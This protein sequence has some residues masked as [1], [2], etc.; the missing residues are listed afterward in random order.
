MATPDGTGLAHTH[1]LLLLL[2]YLAA[3]GLGHSN[4]TGVSDRID[5]HTYKPDIHNPK[6]SFFFN[7]AI[8]QHGKALAGPA[9]DMVRY[10]MA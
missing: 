1:I 3:E 2:Q 9:R 8:N 6:R 5:T 4:G 7:F 10:G